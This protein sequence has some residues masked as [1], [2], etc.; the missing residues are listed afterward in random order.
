VAETHALHV[1]DRHGDTTTLWRTDDAAAIAEAEAVFAAM[2]DAKYLA[3]TVNGPD[4]FEKVTAFDPAARE[5]WMTPQHQ[6]G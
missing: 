1:H 6:G 5:T 3:Y 2:T 4:D